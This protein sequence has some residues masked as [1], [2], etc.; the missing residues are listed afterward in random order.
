MKEEGRTG[1]GPHRRRNMKDDFTRK[2]RIT[3]DGVEYVRADARDYG[4]DWVYSET[5]TIAQVRPIYGKS[6]FLDLRFTAMPKT[7][8]K[9][10]M[11]IAVRIIE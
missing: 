2:D 6:A 8:F 7:R 11:K 5:L 10:G 3:I 4:M 1:N 9:P